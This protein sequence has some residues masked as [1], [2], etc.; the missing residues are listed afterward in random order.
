MSI[1]LTIKGQTIE[2]PSSAA[3]PNWA[4]GVI[5]FAQA[6]EEAINSIAGAFD[7]SPQVQNIDASN[8]ATNVDITNLVFPV[9]DV[10]G[11]TIF[12]AV[13]RQT[14]ES[15]LGAGDD[16]AVNEAGQLEL[17]YNNGSGVWEFTR[18]G[19]GDAMIDFDV[20]NTGQVR[21][22]TQALTGI[23]HTGRITFRALSVLNS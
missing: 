3:S 15:S 2:F 10:Q 21:Y 14:D 1:I 12:Y 13:Y 22:S 4:P 16:Q 6:V 17:S 20:T 7:V 9:S 18:T 5:E 19:V 8:P 11:V 23:N